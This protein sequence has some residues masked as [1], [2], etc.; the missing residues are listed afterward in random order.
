MDNKKEETIKIAN[1][2]V[3]LLGEIPGVEL[4]VKEVVVERPLSYWNEANH[5]LF[6]EAYRCA[7]CTFL[8]THNTVFC[9]GCGKKMENP[10]ELFVESYMLR[11]QETQKKEGCNER[12]QNSSR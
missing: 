1:A 8:A 10:G 9:P 4:P 11:M 3:S 12:N 2:I 6:F 5:P 7:D